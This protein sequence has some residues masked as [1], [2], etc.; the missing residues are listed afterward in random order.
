MEPIIETNLDITTTIRSVPLFFDLNDSQ[1]EKI[2][3]ITAVVEIDPGDTPIREGS[4]LDFLYILLEGEIKVDV[5]VPTRG[6]IETS[7]LGPLD[8]IG[9]SALTP[10]V[11]QRASTSTALTHCKLLRINA[12][13]LATLCEK[14]HD[15][16]FAIYRRVANV[17]ATSFL[18]TRIQ[19]MSL[20]AESL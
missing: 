15:I 5:F 1:I 18:N 12:R 11:R 4:R 2:A 3:R 16:G 7:R 13:L 8:L 6:T 14:E 19:L 9:W 17:T 20:I 10:V